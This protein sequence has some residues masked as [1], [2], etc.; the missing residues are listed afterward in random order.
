MMIYELNRFEK[1]F[2]FC[3]FDTPDRLQHMFWRFR[4]IDHP[5]NRGKVNS[6]EMTTII[7]DH[8]RACDSIV[9][10]VLQYVDDQT[11]LIVLSDH[12]MK[13]FQRGFHL[14]TWLYNNN[15]LALKNGIQLGEEA[16]D[17]L[18]SVDWSRTKAYALGLGGIYLNL[19]GR[20]EEG[21]VA[22]GEAR[23]VEAAIVNGLTCLHDPDKNKL[24][25]RSVISREQVY[26]GPYAHESPDL[27]VNFADGYRVSWNTALGGIPQGQFEDN[28]KKWSGDHSIDP[29]LVPGVLFMN[30]KF[31][32]GRASLIDLAPTILAIFGIQKDPPM[33]G[34]SLLI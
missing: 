8:Y 1:G 26:S 31:A 10:K 33:E 22:A 28:L 34:K 25:I 27:I 17:F 19:K 12:G 3:L 21:I 24:A 16:G 29:E 13:S 32:E 2:F 30:R 7:E 4:E 11:L 6:E 18:R 9:E 23:G 20:E 5:A 14:N 15:F